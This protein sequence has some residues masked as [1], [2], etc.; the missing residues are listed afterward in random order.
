MANV[1]GN[2]LD[3]GGNTMISREA[4]ILFTLN[5][6]NVMVGSGGVRPDNTR[7]VVPDSNGDFSVNL[8]PTVNMFKDAWYNI[9]IRWLQGADG[10]Q[11]KAAALEGFMDLQLRVPSGGGRLDQL[12]TMGGPGGTPGP[13]GRVV[14]VSQTPPSNPRP[15]MLW[16]EQEPGDS[17]DPFDP[18]NTSDLHEWRP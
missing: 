8:E 4:V 16:L 3:I 15:W 9:S 1:T 10:P 13:N 18:K 6:P 17:P 7:E 5:S 2:L 12:V 14:W 11:G